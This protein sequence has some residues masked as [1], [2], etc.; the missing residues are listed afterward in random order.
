MPLKTLFLNIFSLLMLALN[1]PAHGMRFPVS[2]L[3]YNHKTKYMAVRKDNAD[4]NLDSSISNNPEKDRKYYDTGRDGDFTTDP[5][6]S[7]EEGNEDYDDEEEENKNISLAGNDKKE[8]KDS[9]VTYNGNSDEN[10]PIVS[11]KDQ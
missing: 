4:R 6:S 11:D 7:I 9:Y 3:I 1:P 2:Y 10:P 8:E 5:D